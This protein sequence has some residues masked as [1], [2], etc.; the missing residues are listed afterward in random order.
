MDDGIKKKADI[1]KLDSDYIKRLMEHSDKK[2]P[3]KMAKADPGLTDET[4]RRVISELSDALER[5]G[6]RKISDEE[7]EELK[8]IDEVFDKERLK[9]ETIHSK[10][11]KDDMSKIDK[12]GLPP[13]GQK[14]FMLE[15]NGTT[16]PYTPEPPKSLITG[17][18]P[19]PKE[20]APP[21]K[22]SQNDLDELQ[23]LREAVLRKEAEIRAKTTNNNDSGAYGI[24]E[25]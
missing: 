18:T 8:Y 21:T 7:A 1:N 11:S 15:D 16:R 14:Q 13:E 20:V 23:K 9:Q 2:F 5:G 19:P 3:F 22:I 24:S 17:N 12:M 10:A 4:G 25:Y 6:R